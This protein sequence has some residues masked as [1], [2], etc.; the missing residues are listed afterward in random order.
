MIPATFH[1]LQNATVFIT[2]GGSGIGAALTEAFVAQ[3]AKV[4]FVDIMDASDTARALGE[5]YGNEPLAIQCDVTNVKAL[6]AAMDQTVNT[7]G[8]LKALVNNAAND[9]RMDAL[10]VT[11]EQWAD[12]IEVN[13]KHYFFAC[14]KAGHLMENGGSIINFSSTS[15]M[16]GSP[17]MAPY[18][19]SNAGILGLTRALAR[20]W[21][22]K[23][24]RVNALAPGW[25]LTEKQLAKW[26]TPEALEEF[27]ESLCLKQ[28]LKPEDIPGTV[29]FLASDI[30]KM[31]TAQTLVVDGGKSMLG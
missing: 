22:P 8:P 19:S 25:I 12:M 20:E 21:G 15:Y 29:L 4:G 23:G 31:M 11:E 7:F 2:G 5:R 9:L 26:A 6:H 17:D 30:S 13:L 24:I 3:G 14:Q 1:D 27:R 10:T 16:I 18:V 28:M